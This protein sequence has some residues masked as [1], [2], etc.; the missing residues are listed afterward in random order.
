MNRVLAG[1][2]RAIV[3]FGVAAGVASGAWVAWKKAND[4]PAQARFVT[5]EVTTG[6]LVQTVTANGKLNPVSLVNVGTQ[7]SGTVMRLRADFNDQVKAG[8][9]LL[10]LDPTT[11][12]AAV[13][14]SEGEVK[15]AE[16]SLRLAQASE[17]RL[18]ELHAQEYVSR[19]ELDQAVQARE[20][21]EAQLQIARGRLQRDRAN[22][23]YSVIRSPVS[24]VV[25]SREVD[26]GQTVAASFQTPTLFRI[27]RDLRFMQIDSNVAEAD[28]GKVRVGQHV[29]FTVDAYPERSFEGAV[30]QIR[31]N[32][33]VEQNVVTYNVVV[34]VDNPDLALLPGMTAY[35]S[36]EVDQRHSAL[37][38]PNAALRFR[39]RDRELARTR[40]AGSTVWSVRDGKLA[41]L[42]VRTGITN[43]RLTEI[44]EGAL[45]PGDRV[46]VE[47]LGG[48]SAAPAGP[49]RM[50]LF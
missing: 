42:A 28:I 13:A 35:L 18:R 21:A 23:A 10:E 2:L 49:P 4:R 45:K 47:E 6:A 37:L 3:I 19:E 24:G 11:F 25:V 32:P 1:A 22:L 34:S 50:R 9:V 16:A 20:A 36:I 33:I 8:Q 12:R 30:K 29:R 40:P 39:P 27:A 7:V 5:E 41:P 48:E 31:L 26:V 44:V 43:G 17:A 15:S 46:V 38:V 14:Q